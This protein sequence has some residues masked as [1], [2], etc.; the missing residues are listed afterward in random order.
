MKYTPTD[1]GGVTIVDIEPDRDDR[2]FFSHLFC[3]S[4]FAEYG[5][6]LQRRTDGCGL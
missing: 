4:E 5:L 6:T 1:I 2:G 3:A